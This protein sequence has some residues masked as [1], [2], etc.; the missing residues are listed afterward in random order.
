[1]TKVS[2]ERAGVED[3]GVP[4][5]GKM[6]HCGYYATFAMAA[7]SQYVGILSYQPEE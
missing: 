2:N 4:G 1:M 7:A 6:Q 3:F 5:S